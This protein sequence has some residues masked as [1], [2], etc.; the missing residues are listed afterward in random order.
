MFKH[1]MN[2]CLK[3]GYFPKEWEKA[4]PIL[5]NKEGKRKL[6]LESMS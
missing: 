2:L 3:R 4:T 5:F 6:T 1:I